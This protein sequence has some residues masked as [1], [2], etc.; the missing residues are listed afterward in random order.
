[1]SGEWER[2]TTMDGA[3]ESGE[4]RRARTSGRGDGGDDEATRFM[5]PGCRRGMIEASGGHVGAHSEE[6][7]FDQ[8]TV[9][10]ENSSF[11]SDTNRSTTGD[12]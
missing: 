10:A 5:T 8:R 2:V 12:C 11:R 1:M 6:C 3:G 4:T 9:T 7:A